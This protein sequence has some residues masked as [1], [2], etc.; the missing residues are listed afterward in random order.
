MSLI[1]RRGVA[2][3]DPK[4]GDG[5][6]GEQAADLGRGQ[7]DGPVLAGMVPGIG[8]GGRCRGGGAGHQEGEGEHGQGDVAVPAGPGPDL[9][10]VEADRPLGGLELFFSTPAASRSWARTNPRR[11]SRAASASHT[12]VRSSRCIACGSECP[13]CS[14]SHQQF[15][16][17]A[18]D[19]NPAT[20]SRA[21]RRGSA[22]PN[23]PAT[24]NISPSNSSCHRAGLRCGQRPPRHHWASTQ[25]HMIT[26]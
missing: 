19:S 26:R 15:F 2:P 18:S 16:R 13:A 10:V 24:R 21:V 1:T 11:S 3:P 23:R 20:K 6:A 22:R 5:Q 9:V 4:W 17:S 8:W 25:P 14:A 7:R 12:A